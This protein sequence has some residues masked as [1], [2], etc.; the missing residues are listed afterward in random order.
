MTTVT[1]MKLEAELVEASTAFN[2]AFDR[3]YGRP[4]EI[5]ELSQ[6]LS[7]V[8]KKATHILGRVMDVQDLDEWLDHAEETG[9]RRA[10]KG[11]EAR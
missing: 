4:F 1:M 2:I 7:A 11:G 9:R 6:A 8:R 5:Q 3:P 10:M